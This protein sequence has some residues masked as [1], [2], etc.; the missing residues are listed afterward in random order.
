MQPRDRWLEHRPLRRYVYTRRN[1][2]A[3]RPHEASKWL[4]RRLHSTE[5]ALHIR[6][7]YAQVQKRVRESE[8]VAGP[9]QIAV[10]LELD[11]SRRPSDVNLVLGAI[12]R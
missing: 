3:Q 10:Q 11:V 8:L 12:R 6:K 7:C 1:E 5:R 4:E 9:R 2:G